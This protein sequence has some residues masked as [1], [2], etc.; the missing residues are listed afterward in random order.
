MSTSLNNLGFTQGFAPDQLDRLAEIATPVQ[1]DT[2]TFIF[3]EGDVGSG[4]FVVESGCVAIEVAIPGRGRV[5]ILTVGPGEVFG[6]SGVF[7]RRPKT[8]AARATEATRAWALDADR[9]RDL[10][11]ADPR[12]DTC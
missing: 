2:D 4:L 8:A 5:I 12:L 7:H 11:E 10:C 9:L 3:R 1:W 6:W